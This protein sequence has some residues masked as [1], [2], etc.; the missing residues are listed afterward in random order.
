[1]NFTFASLPLAVHLISLLICAIW[2]GVAVPRVAWRELSEGGIS[3]RWLGSMV[4]VA[5]L[6]SMKGSIGP[7]F[8]LH[9][10]GAATL[11]LMIGFPLATLALV[12]GA[13]AATF[14]AGADWLAL[15]V[16]LV[17]GSL[18]PSLVTHLL[19][20]Y[21]ERRLAP[22]FFV[23]IFILTCFGA[24]LGVVLAGAVATGLLAGFSTQ[25]LADLL[26]DY[27]PYYLLL[28]FSEAWLS[29][30]VITL[31]TIWLPGWVVSFDDQRYLRGK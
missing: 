20:R 23:F 18:V 2:V 12:V 5:L 17:I 4:V 26:S 15:P 14:N 13:A 11:T 31:M 21:G 19:L 25:T 7:G 16:N 3:H 28:G 6:W 1:M 9:L 29:G 22:N 8:D 30:A 27:F 24:A 10:L